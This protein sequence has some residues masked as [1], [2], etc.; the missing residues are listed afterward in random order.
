ME[1]HEPMGTDRPAETAI[2]K[3]RSRL[4]VAVVVGLDLNG[5]GV[6]R[7]LARGRV[8]TLVLDTDFLKP[9]AATRFGRR[10]KVPALSGTTFIDALHEAAARFTEKPV[11]FLTQEGSVE[12]VAAARDSVLA[13][14]RFTMPTHDV[15]RSLMN[16]GGF[17][18][19]AEELHSAIPRSIRLTKDVTPETFSSLRFPCVVK[20][21][22][23]EDSYSV[24]FKK[25]YKVE[26]ADELERLWHVLQ[27]T[28]SEMIV[29]EWIEGSDSDVY[30]C[31][32]YRPQSAPP[33]SFV[34]RKICQWPPLVGGTASCAPAPEAHDELVSLTNT[35]FDRVG[36]VGLGSMEYKRD[37][38]DGRFYMVEPTV[39]R[40]DYQEEIATL[41]G[42]NIPYAAYC[43]EIGR[44]NE[45]IV[46]IQRPRMWRDMASCR[47][48]R[49]AGAV[50]RAFE[51]SPDAEIVDAM[52][53]ANDPMPF[54]LMK[55]EPL[56]RRVRRWFGGR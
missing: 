35:F 19:L 30:F 8:P 1:M 22:K 48:A 21:L 51:I 7:S 26:S 29:Q 6:V 46:S 27:G 13:S 17:Q 4:P 54:L 42:V 11:L 49:A 34:G 52:Y 18:R 33:V 20:P 40:T 32:Q 3:S 24:K 31:L 38:R 25:A 43:A 28:A 16:K 55:L 53:R 56:E 10:L 39:G 23:K 5:L 37:V 12:A 47:K 15:M 2:K 14:Y 44:P 36:F 50:D 45:S 9:T 41:N